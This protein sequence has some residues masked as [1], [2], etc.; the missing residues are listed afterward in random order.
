MEDLERIQKGKH[1]PALKGLLDKS[2]ANIILNV[3]KNQS[4]LFKI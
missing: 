1:L 4:K 2:M 3:E